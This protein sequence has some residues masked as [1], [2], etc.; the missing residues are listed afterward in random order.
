MEFWQAEQNNNECDAV[1]KETWLW[2]KHHLKPGK[3][4]G[5]S[6]NYK[7]LTIFLVYFN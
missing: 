4:C 1:E 6:G 3:V 7:I 2:G 5:P